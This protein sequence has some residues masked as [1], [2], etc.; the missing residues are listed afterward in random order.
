MEC[1]SKSVVADLKGL[2]SQRLA[3]SAW[4]R[5]KEETIRNAIAQRTVSWKTSLSS[6][7]R[8]GVSLEE[9]V[10]EIPLAWEILHSDAPLHVLDAGAA[11]A[12][13]YIKDLMDRPN[14]KVTHFTQKPDGI[15]LDPREGR[16]S[17][18]F[19]DL[20][21]LDFQPETFDRVVCI[22]TLEHIGFNNTRY[23]GERENSPRSFLDAFRELLRVAKRA[24]QV[25]VT[26]PYGHPQR[27]GWFQVLGPKDVK[28]LKIIGKNWK[29]KEKYYYFNG[30]WAE[31]SKN[32]DNSINKGNDLRDKVRGV[33]ALRFIKKPQGA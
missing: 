23:G 16:H 25:M 27:H 14:L 26:F 13:D 4:R 24:G 22:S 5:H 12:Q 19:G 28:L 17:Y 18:V 21:H 29:V 10:V 8:F 3:K 6:D 15:S 31:G 2:P 9:R 32:V 30:F 7:A 33:V 1:K 20:R 11:L